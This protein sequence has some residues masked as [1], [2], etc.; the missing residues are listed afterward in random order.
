MAG[1]F[2]AAMNEAIF[3]PIRAAYPGAVVSNFNSGRHLR[4][5]AS[6]D[7]NGHLDR[8][9]TAGF[10]SHDNF[11]FYGWSA[12]RRLDIA[13]G[14][15]PS[16]EA[17]TVFRVEMH[18][19]RGMNASSSRS[20]HAWIG[21]RSWEGEWYWPVRFASTPIWDE[22]VLQLGMHGVRQFLEL[23]MEDFSVSR[24]VNLERRAR[25][26]QALDALLRELNERVSGSSGGL[27]TS[28]QP[29]WDDQVIAT[30]RRVGD[31]VVW[32][33]SFAPGIDAVRVELKDGSEAVIT[34][35]E[36]RRGAWFEHG[37]DTGLVTDASGRRP[38]MELIALSSNP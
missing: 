18:K 27:L 11:E 30:G 1:R 4:A 21:Q 28:L 34:A 23:S 8:R 38:K 33:F 12:Q 37:A 32:R 2:D 16:D 25:D 13:R 14:V 10:G 5:F 15:Q 35:E 24:E 6:P 9:Q 36:G 22:L 26:R 31:R 20:K 7:V 17:W 3:A 19:I 29:S